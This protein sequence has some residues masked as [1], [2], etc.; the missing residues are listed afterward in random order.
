MKAA[1]IAASQ[2]PPRSVPGKTGEAE[3]ALEPSVQAYPG[4]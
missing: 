2:P 4:T 3:V 1:K